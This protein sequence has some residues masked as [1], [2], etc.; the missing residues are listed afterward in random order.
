MTP[1]LFSIV[2]IALLFGL[3]YNPNS[4]QALSA[5]IRKKAHK[6]ETYD[7]KKQQVDVNKTVKSYGV[8]PVLKKFNKGDLNIK[9]YEIDEIRGLRIFNNI[10]TLNWAWIHETE[11]GTWR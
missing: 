9:L 4:V 6:D 10:Q 2:I 5:N 7:H 1:L 11:D 8:I 3:S